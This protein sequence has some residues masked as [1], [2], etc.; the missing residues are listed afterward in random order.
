[1]RLPRVSTWLL[2]VREVEREE[3]RLQFTPKFRSVSFRLMR[4]S[5]PLGVSVSDL[6]TVWQFRMAAPWSSAERRSKQFA[7]RFEGKFRLRKPEISGKN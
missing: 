3:I 4:Q 5:R 6:G 2:R 1:M 7:V